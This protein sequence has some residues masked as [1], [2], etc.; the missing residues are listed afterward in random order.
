MIVAVVLLLLGILG[1]FWLRRSQ[2]PGASAD[3]ET[4]A[5]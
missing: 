3:A 1:A 5:P 2:T 4:P